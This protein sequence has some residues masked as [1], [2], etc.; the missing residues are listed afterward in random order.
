[1]PNPSNSLPTVTSNIPRDLR[2]F[3]DRLRDWVGAQGVSELVTPAYLQSVGLL[4]ANFNPTADE[5]VFYATPP[6]PTNLQVSTVEA[7]A[8][9]TWDEPVYTGHAYTEVWASDTND[10]ADANVVLTAP[11]SI[12]VYAMGRDRTLYFWVRFVNVVNHEGA[13][14][15]VGGTVG[16]TLP[17]VD[18][19]LTALNGAITEAELFSTLGARINLIDDPVTGIAATR[20]TL[21]N[22]Y[23]TSVS[24]DNAISSAVSTLATTVNGN[25]AAISTQATSIDG[26]S[27][28]YTVKVDNNGYVTGYGLASTLIN[29]TPTSE[30]IVRADRFAISSPGE[31]EIAPFVVT[32]TPTTL[33]GVAV[34]AGV[35]MS[36]AFIKNG[37]ITNAKIGNATIDDAKIVSLT[38]N[39]ITAGSL[40]AGSYIRSTNYIAG[41]AGFNIPASGAAEFNNVTIRGGGSFGGALS[42][43]T[44]TFAGAL[45][46]ATGTFA[47]ALSAATGTFTGDLSAATGTFSGSLNV[48]SAASG[49]RMEITDDVIKVFDGSTLRVKIGNLA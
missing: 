1:M 12:G 10:L 21:T 46:A 11:G 19:L 17:K 37:A 28:Q 13:Y 33:N 16:T 49:S 7:N 9:L 22:D 32:T 29:G 43:A 4:D 36:E 27:A 8:L 25:T 26:L 2:L 14:N 15:A 3:L 23:Y 35:Y 34:P 40:S 30:F 20:A 18:D 38:A 39:K 5:G 24:T 42:A 48:A 45:S 6:P 41:S 31:V 44:G 47:G